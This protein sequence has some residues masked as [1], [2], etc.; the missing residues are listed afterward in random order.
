MTKFLKSKWWTTFV[1]LLDVAQI[2]G[3]FVATDHYLPGLRDSLKLRK[4]AL[5]AKD[6]A[7]AKLLEPNVHYYGSFRYYG[8]M[9][10]FFMNLP[11]LLNLTLH[12]SCRGFRAVLNST[13]IFD[14]IIGVTCFAI[15]TTLVSFDSSIYLDPELMNFSFGSKTFMIIVCLKLLPI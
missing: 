14:V 12:I 8:L 10:S 1:L 4:D 6:T 7:L 2:V 15:G 9:T 3:V 13:M 11:S 5:I